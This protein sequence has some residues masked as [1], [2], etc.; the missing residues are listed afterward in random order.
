[1]SRVLRSPGGLFSALI[2]PPVG[3]L[4]INRATKAVFAPNQPPAGYVEK[5]KTMQAIRPGAFRHNAKEISALSDWAKLAAG[6]YRHIKT[7][8]IIITGD[9]DKIVSPDIH[10]RH[11]ARDIPGARL[12]VVHN[13]GHKSDYIANDLAIAAIERVAG[14]KVDLLGIAR[15]VEKRI[16]NDRNE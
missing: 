16:A 8:T 1:M 4:A 11:L 3:L 9:T 7:P 14:R 6:Q 12:I 13:L 2:V 10:A 5:T 15:K